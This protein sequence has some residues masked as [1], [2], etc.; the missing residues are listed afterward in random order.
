MLQDRA[1]PAAAIRKRQNEML[2]DEYVV[3]GVE[4]MRSG[5]REA[6]IVVLN[7]ALEINPHCVEALVARGAALEVQGDLE[8]ARSK[9]EKVLRLKED[10]RARTALAKL[11][12]KKRSP[13]VEILDN[14]NDKPKSKNARR[15]DVEEE[16]RKRRST[17]EA[18]RE[19][20]RERHDNRKKL[21]EMEEF[22]KALREKK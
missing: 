13:S 20:K 6:A 21:R 7:Q 12:R 4:H 22:I 16:K 15:S 5:N 2:A 3:R 1:E 9:F 10:R 19:R 17:Q 8:N 14:D 18:E 11:D